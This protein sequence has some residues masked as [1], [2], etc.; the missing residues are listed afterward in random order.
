MFEKCLLLQKYKQ[1]H[2]EVSVRSGKCAL[3][4]KLGQQQH[5]PFIE[6]Y[7]LALVKQKETLNSKEQ[8]SDSFDA[9]ESAIIFKGLNAVRLHIF[10]SQIDSR[11]DLFHSSFLSIFTF[12]FHLL[13]KLIKNYKVH[14]AQTAKFFFVTHQNVYYK[15]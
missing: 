1:A 12:I 14:N 11:S 7:S 15:S 13:R 2:K 10:G 8:G 5:R 9:L 6:Q 4:T 3:I